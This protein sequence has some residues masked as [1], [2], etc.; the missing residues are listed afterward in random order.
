MLKAR[1]RGTAP[2]FRRQGKTTPRRARPSPGPPVVGRRRH[3]RNTRHHPAL[4]PRAR[5]AKMDVRRRSR[6]PRWP[7]GPHS[8]PGS[9]DGHGEPDVGLHPNPRCLKELGPSGRSL[10]DCAHLESRGHP[11]QSRTPNDVADIH[12][13]ALAGAAGGGFLH[14][15]GV[16]PPRQEVA[17]AGFV[18]DAFDR[19]SSPSGTQTPGRPSRCRSVSR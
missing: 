16:D 8:S 19:F 10:D 18:F 2:A 12:A 5:G 14:H 3:D 1:L 7:A 13:R 4:A 6:Q 17:L 15:G 11:A 9:A